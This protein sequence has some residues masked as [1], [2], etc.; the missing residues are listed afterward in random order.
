MKFQ[1]S[2]EIKVQAEQMLQGLPLENFC[3]HLRALHKHCKSVI[4]VNGDYVV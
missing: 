1:D 3:D 2:K 4:C